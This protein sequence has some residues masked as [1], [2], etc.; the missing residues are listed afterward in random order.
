MWSYTLCAGRCVGFVKTKFTSWIVPA[1][2]LG[3]CLILNR[4]SY[5]NSKSQFPYLQNKLTLPKCE[6]GGKVGLLYTQVRAQH[7]MRSKRSANTFSFSCTRHRSPS[8][9]AIFP[10][11]W[12][13]FILRNTH[14]EDTS[15]EV[16]QQK[17]REGSLH[18]ELTT[19]I[20]ALL[21]GK[22][23]F[24]PNVKFTAWKTTKL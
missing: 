7:R 11:N 22:L 2:C 19:R 15:R 4:D 10:S 24:R 3:R 9:W 13:K 1:S 16:F 21:E 6:L 20:S 23:L 5:L 14:W 18:V 8:D 17:P 12:Q